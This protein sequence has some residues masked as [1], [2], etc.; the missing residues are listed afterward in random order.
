M[1]ELYS[2]VHMFQLGG[3]CAEL[4]TSAHIQAP[5]TFSFKEHGSLFETAEPSRD[6][7]SRLSFA[8]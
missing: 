5:K 8:L 2:S 4:N 3:L 7:C 6:E 1:V